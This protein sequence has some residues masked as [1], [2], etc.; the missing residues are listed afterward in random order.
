MTNKRVRGEIFDKGCSAS[1]PCDAWVE[2]CFLQIQRDDADAPEQ[3]R[4]LTVS[5]RLAGV[6][7]QLHFESD[8]VFVSSDDD[9]VNGL[10]S[11]MGARDPFSRLARLERWSPWLAAGLSVLFLLA[12]IGLKYGL[13]LASDLATRLFPASIERELGQTSYDA[14][15]RF[16]LK[17]S[18]LTE[19]HQAEV[20]EVFASIRAAARVSPQTRL[21]IHSVPLM[22]ANAFAFPGGPIVITDKLVALAP[23]DDVLKGVFAHELAHIEERHGLKRMI[24]ALGWAAVMSALVGDGGE[25]LEEAA[26]I[27]TLLMDRA[28]SRRFETEADARSLELLVSVGAN[29]DGFAE[30]LRRLAQSCGQ[31]CDQTGLLS[32]H[33][34]LLERAKRL[35]Q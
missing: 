35:T 31:A 28:Y 8:R 15:A 20:Q 22:G 10:L 24:R 32:T 6:A 27:P 12:L 9:G 18:V 7:R 34:S 33:P 23:N 4:I 30:L 11:A 1:T 2:R 25:L 19:A 29:P 14:V 21:H 16:L 17:P 5:P 3:E 13:P 26:A